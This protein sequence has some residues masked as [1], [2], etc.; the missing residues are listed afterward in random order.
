MANREACD[1]F[2][3]INLESFQILKFKS[4][5]TIVFRI[6]GHL[7]AFYFLYLIIDFLLFEMVLRVHYKK[8]F[9][10]DD[11]LCINVAY[12]KLNNNIHYLS[13]M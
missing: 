1:K 3:Y 10:Y 11:Y 13:N 9:K 7:T 5:L 12:R 8:T 6:N 2:Q 4:Y